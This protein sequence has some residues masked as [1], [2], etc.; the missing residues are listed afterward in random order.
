MRKCIQ[1]SP[2][3]R[4]LDLYKI[5]RSCYKET[6]LYVVK[7]ILSQC[8]QIISCTTKAVMMNSGMVFVIILWPP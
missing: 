1:L 2:I 3:F 6:N 5:R 8:K 7:V 4:C